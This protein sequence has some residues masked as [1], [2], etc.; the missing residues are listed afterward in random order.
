[1]K[2]G[3]RQEQTTQ[4]DRGVNPRALGTNP[5]AMKRVQR[6]MEKNGWTPEMQ[7]P[8]D[9][10]LPKWL[11]FE[12]MKRDGFCCVYCGAR[13]ADGVRLQVDH[14]V[15]RAKGGSDDP[16]NLTTSCQPCNS[17]KGARDL[18]EAWI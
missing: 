15:P 12:V 10:L 17:G 8:G 14:I 3:S 4:R 1:M 11:R 18:D 2:R 7:A 13:P 16:Q 9:K 6:A 5:R